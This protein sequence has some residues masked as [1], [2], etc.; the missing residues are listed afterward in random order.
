[1]IAAACGPTTHWAGRTI[2]REGEVFVREGHDP[3]SAAGFIECDRQ[4]P[5]V[6][7]DDGPRHAAYRVPT[8]ARR[9]QPPVN[10]RPSRRSTP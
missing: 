2:T 5:V 10:E 3:V 4:A 6:W 1:M 8:W 7:V 9:E